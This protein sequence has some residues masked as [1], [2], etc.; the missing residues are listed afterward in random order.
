MRERLGRPGRNFCLV[1]LAGPVLAVL[2]TMTGGACR[3]NVNQKNV[4]QGVK[5]S[6]EQDDAVEGGALGARALAKVPPRVPFEG[7]RFRPSL[8]NLAANQPFQPNHFAETEACARCHQT[9]YS[10]WSQSMHRF[11]SLNNPFY[12]ASFADFIGARGADNARFCAGCHDPSL[13]LDANVPLALDPAAPQAHM[14]M[15]CLGCHSAVDAKTGGNGHYTLATADPQI[16]RQ[17]PGPNASPTEQAQYDNAVEAHVARVRPSALRTDTLCI[18]CHRGALTPEMGHDVVALGLDEW[19]PWRRSAYN[20]NHATRLDDQAPPAQG[21]RDCHMPD[22]DGVRSHRF[23]GGHTAFAA[24]L[25]RNEGA[26]KQLAAQKQVLNDTVALDI[27]FR[28]DRKPG[29]GAPPDASFDLVFDVVVF[30]EA[31]GHNFPAGARDMRDT[32]LEVQVLDQA[33][34]RLA[35][36]GTGHAETGREPLAYVFHSRVLQ[37][38]G[39]TERAHDVSH[40]RTPVYDHTLGPRDSLVVRYGVTLPK[41]LSTFSVKARVRHRR[42]SLESH[43]AGCGFAQGDL[44]QRFV[45]AT[46]RFTGMSV[47]ACQPQ[48]IVDVAQVARTWTASTSQTQRTASV[49]GA[50]STAAD[51]P[52]PVVRTQIPPWRRYY[53]YGLGLLHQ[54]QEKLGE[55]ERAFQ[56]SLT[57]LQK[58]P[59][60]TDRAMAMVQQGLARVYGRT[61]RIERAK[62]TLD[63]VHRL[64]PDQASVWRDVGDANMAVWRFE[65]AAAAY[66]KADK[67]Q[68]DDRVLIPWATALSSAGQHQEA[69]RV[70]QRGLSIEGRNPQLL[71]IQHLAYQKLGLPADAVATGAKN[72]RRREAPQKNTRQ[73]IPTGGPPPRKPSRPTNGTFK[74]PISGPC[75][76]SWTRT[77]VQNAPPSRCAG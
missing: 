75:A 48:P 31:V 11:S 8:A 32:W 9:V 25:A 15:T 42:L 70:A 28:D 62:N 73:K 37:A 51:E 47:D 12:L 38:S 5:Q 72:P 50:A 56:R 54:V 67:I 36:S 20:S 7:D 13:L 6:I 44:G 46:K 64:W 24:A 77:A 34:R 23:P 3:Q 59:T 4:N 1:C 66:A 58:D 60:Q 74:R 52:A 43:Q 17:A 71:R 45:K 55:A 21:C 35:S 76:S 19:G 39:S 30:N 27:F 29:R 26:D 2:A 40:F 53:R 14:G 65:P 16:P 61:S 18:S 49:A 57:L 69:L 68:K 22:E 10:Q 41:R 33:G 63:Q